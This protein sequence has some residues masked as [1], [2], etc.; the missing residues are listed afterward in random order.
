MSFS[1][2]RA[3]ESQALVTVVSMPAEIKIIIVIP[4]RDDWSK[5]G[6]MWSGPLQRGVGRGAIVIQARFSRREPA[7]RGAESGKAQR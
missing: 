4:M 1:L 2:I 3:G 5:K 6:K 7:I